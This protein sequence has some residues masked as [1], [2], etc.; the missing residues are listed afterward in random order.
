MGNR[1]RCQ[2]WGPVTL[3]QQTIEAAK[4]AGASAIGV[5]GAE[6]FEEARAAMED[7][8]ETGRSGPLGFTYN[9]LE[10]STD[11]RLSLPWARS[12]VV[13]GVS[14][15]DRALSP[16]PTG[17]II[18]RFATPNHYE[19]VR[20]VA[21]AVRACLAESGA[22]AEVLIDDNR[23]VDR[24]AAVRAGVGWFGRSTMVLAPG[25]GPWMLLGSVVTDTELDRTEPMKRDCGTCTACIPACPT[26]ALDGGVLDARRCL[27]TWLQTAGSIPLW[28]R[29]VL[30][31]RIYG[32]DDC[33]TS[34]P[35]GHPSLRASGPVS[36]PLPFAA[37]LDSDDD[38]LL[39]RHSWWYV[40]RRD[41]RFI[42]RNL[43]VAGG[44]SGEPSVLPAL[45]EHL[46]HPSSMIRG[47]AAWAVARARGPEGAGPIRQALVRE[48]SPEA[49]EEMLLALLQAQMPE[50]YA[51]IVRLDELTTTDNRFS[52]LGLAGVG[53]DT[54]ELP[55]TGIE[56]IVVERD[57]TPQVETGVLAGAIRVNDRQRALEQLRRQARSELARTG[58]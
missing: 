47:H 25:Q 12:I 5:T 40:P 15:I 49:R 36:K 13:F 56:P 23:L 16:A 29:P 18:G 50:M 10:V 45:M 57:R 43:L 1:E 46:T 42:R 53:L 8:V 2:T 21:E 41:G 19:E 4:A 32:C 14:Y 6:P 9:D 20:R 26:G 22:K 51:E 39:D 48:R 52:A 38:E 11:I 55:D 28:V 44:N 24:S 27:S 35:P 31:R 33:L 37:L 7:S 34:C 30:G 17:P 3:T 54:N 58:R